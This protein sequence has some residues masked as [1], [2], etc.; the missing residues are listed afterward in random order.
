MKYYVLSVLSGCVWAGI[1]LL[2]SFGAYG[3]LITG[4][5]IAAPFIG[6]LI[7]ILY[8]PAYKFS[9]FVQILGSLFTLYLAAALFGLAVGA[10]DWLWRDIPNRMLDEVVLQAMLA[11][12]FGVTFTGY[13]VLLWPL[14][15]LNHWLLSKATVNSELGTQA[16]PAR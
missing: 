15:F 13:V 1:A 3:W 5:I 14:A 9:T 7:G 6:L 2:L 8:R 4:G 11:T 10:G 12:L 16:R